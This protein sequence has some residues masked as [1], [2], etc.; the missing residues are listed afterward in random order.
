MQQSSQEC[1][2][3]GTTEDDDDVWF[4]PVWEDE[5][6]GE[7]LDPPG[8][9][10]SARPHDTATLDAA[11][12]LAPLAKA[13]AALA[14]LDARLEA[15]DPA[16]AAGLRARLALR[17]AAGWLA[18]QEGSWVHPVDLG[19]RAASLTGSITAAAMAGRLRATLPTTVPTTADAGPRPDAPA[20]DLAVGQ[21]LQLG[22]LWLRLAEHRSWTPLAD[23]ASLRPLLDQLGCHEPAEDAS[24]AWLARFAARPA[25]TDAAVPA[26]LRAGQAALAWSQRQPEQ[27]RGDHL[28]TAALFLA[29]CAWRHAGGTPALA[30]PFW[31]ATPARLEALGRVAGPAW[32]PGFLGAVTDA[33]Q[34]AG[35]EL[36]RLQAAA[37]R[38]AA[39]RRTARSQLPA[40]AALALRLPVLTARG[41]AD[42]L[43][44]SPQAALILLKQLVAAGVLREATGRAS[45]RAF[46]VA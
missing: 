41:L 36:S 39:L 5:P 45:W 10:P 1:R 2:K 15:T 4:R 34:R 29:A 32:L 46:V 12:L 26:L 6:A 30:L 37:A 9:P 8:L 25:A 38:A 7:G 28:P 17:E 23:A 27:G 14:R 22:Q 35:Q 3:L 33:A 40:A 18:H 42:R 20:E 44:L 19:L 43:R 16:V 13:S 24:A 31:S 21:A 11:A